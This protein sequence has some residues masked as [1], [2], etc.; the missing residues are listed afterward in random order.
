MNQPNPYS[1]LGVSRSATAQEIKAAYRD[2]VKRY[3]PDRYPLYAQK[4]WATRKMQHINEAYATLKDPVRRNAYD[5]SHAESFEPPT[6]QRA[7]R[8]GFNPWSKA[9]L[10]GWIAASGIIFVWLFSFPDQEIFNNWSRELAVIV[11]VFEVMLIAV[12]SAF[13]GAGLLLYAA[14]FIL[15]LYLALVESFHD[16]LRLASNR[17]GKLWLDLTVR[18]VL[19]G[20][21]VSVFVFASDRV[22][23]LFFVALWSGPIFIVL[24]L[25]GELAALVTHM[26]RARKVAESTEVLLR[27]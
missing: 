12:V 25:V 22:R 20:I 18:L 16:R 27:S 11:I 4:L 26:Y 17:A 13:A 7:Q 21:G 23:G 8:G 3:H 10:Y 6:T 9:I 2:L 5:E 15:G 1:L 24:A 19:L 14:V